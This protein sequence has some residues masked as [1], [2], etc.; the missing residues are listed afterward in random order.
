MHVGN[1]NKQR[2]GEKQRTQETQTDKRKEKTTEKN[3][4]YQMYKSELEKNT[5]T[6]KNGETKNENIMMKKEQ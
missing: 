2:K 4:E 5:G 1:S 6:K 3:E